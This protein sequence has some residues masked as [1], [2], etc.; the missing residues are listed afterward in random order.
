MT[1]KAA[2]KTAKGQG[3]KLLEN[4]AEVEQLIS[5]FPGENKK[6]KI[7]SFVKMF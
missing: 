2:E 5:F 3:K 4:E 6:E 1:G 7:Y